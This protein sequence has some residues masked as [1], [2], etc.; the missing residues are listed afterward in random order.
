[1]AKSRWAVTC[2]PTHYLFRT[3]R[4]NK[5]ELTN[6]FASVGVV[7]NDFTP[8]CLNFRWN[9]VSSPSI[10]YILTNKYYNNSHLKQKHLVIII[11]YF[12]ADVDLEP[13]PSVVTELTVH[14]P[15]VET[16]LF[17]SSC[18]DTKSWVSGRCRLR[19]LWHV[20][21]I[22]VSIAQCLL[23]Q[24]SVTEQFQCKLWHRSTVGWEMGYRYLLGKT[25]WGVSGGAAQKRNE[26]ESKQGQHKMIEKNSWW[27]HMNEL[28]DC[29]VVT[30]QQSCRFPD[31]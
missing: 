7:S 19:R 1:M 10:E 4:Q 25:V 9:F 27:L 18:K 21:W 8:L 14:F 2:N 13:W 29:F 17:T 16:L 12:K 24:H 20:Q 5:T 11:Q 23:S 30:S 26:R 28:V 15:S 3:C 22:R 6:S 31:G